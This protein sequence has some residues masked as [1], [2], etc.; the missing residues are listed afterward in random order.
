MATKLIP[1]AVK[2]TAATLD[3]HEQ[4][5]RATEN[6]EAYLRS[7]RIPLTAWAHN[8]LILSGGEMW[9]GIKEDVGV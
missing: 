5:Q 8:D 9:P 6:H 7:M 3:I 1:I 2:S 4:T